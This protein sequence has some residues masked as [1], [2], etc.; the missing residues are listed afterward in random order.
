MHSEVNYTRETAES[1]RIQK[2]QTRRQMLR[3]IQYCAY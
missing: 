1:C 2:R 3:G